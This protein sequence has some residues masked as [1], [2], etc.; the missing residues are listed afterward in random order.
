[1]LS[2][3]WPTSVYFFGHTCRYVKTKGDQKVRNNVLGN[4]ANGNAPPKKK[5]NLKKEV[6]ILN[7]KDIEEILA[8]VQITTNIS[9]RYCEDNS[10]FSLFVQ[11]FTKS[12]GEAPFK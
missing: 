6:P 10:H 5:R 9:I 4:E 8:E 1:M 12:I 3:K 11:A 7:K 2:R